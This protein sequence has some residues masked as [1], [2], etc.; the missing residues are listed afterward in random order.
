MIKTI[1]IA[2]FYIR[3]RL[4]LDDPA[5][6]GRLWAF[7]GPLAVF[8]SNLSNATVQLQPDFQTEIVYLDSRGRIRIVPLQVIVTVFAFLFSPITV[9]ALW[10]A[11]ASSRQ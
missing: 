7:L 1:H 10:T 2:G 11:F 9:S 4:G 8:V 5:D 6:T 3:L